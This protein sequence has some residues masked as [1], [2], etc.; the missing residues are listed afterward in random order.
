MPHGLPFPQ[1][2]KLARHEADATLFAN[3]RTWKSENIT[4]AVQQ[5]VKTAPA[6]EAQWGTL[7]SAPKEKG[8]QTR[9][10]QKDV[11]N[12]PSEKHTAVLILEERPPERL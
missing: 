7:S 3:M 5:I 1:T 11:R 9:S 4:Y 12:G 2:K 8:Q 10:T 6:T